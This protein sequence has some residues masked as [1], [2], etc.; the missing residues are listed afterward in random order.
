M[1]DGKY[2]S[3]D[4]REAPCSPAT[5]TLYQIV[6]KDDVNPRYYLTPNAAEGILRRVDN[7]NRQLFGPLRDGLEKLSGRRAK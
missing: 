5:S 3:V 2:I 1:W 4:H 7:N 6:E